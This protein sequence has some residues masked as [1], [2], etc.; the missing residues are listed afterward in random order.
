MGRKKVEEMRRKKGRGIGEE[1]VK[2][3]CLGNIRE[4]LR[5]KVGKLRKL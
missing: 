4:R 5:K 1:K 3:R 2:I